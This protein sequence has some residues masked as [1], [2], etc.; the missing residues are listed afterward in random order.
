MTSRIDIPVPAGYQRAVPFDRSK[1]RGLGISSIAS[2]FAAKLHAIY[3]TQAEIHRAALD[4]PVVFVKDSNNTLVPVALVGVEPGQNLFCDGNGDWVANHYIP[5]YVRRYPFFLA[6]LS[7]QDSRGVICVD[8]SALNEDADPLITASGEMAESWPQTQK[9]IEQMDAERPRTQN[10]CAQLQAWDLLEKFD[11]DFHP[12]A[13]PGISTQNQ[14]PQRRINGLMRVN[15]KALFALNDRDLLKSVREGMM[16]H[17]EAHLN[18]LN[19]FD[20]LLNLYAV[21]TSRGD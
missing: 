10:F 21:A 9:L 6:H 12:N 3:L 8:D 20:R 15:R 7:E 2:R 19:R 14:V 4:Y 5:A 11:A 13:I 17:I 18:S 1:H 16:Q